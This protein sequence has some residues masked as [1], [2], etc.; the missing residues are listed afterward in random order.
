MPQPMLI[1]GERVPSVTGEYFEVYD[2]ATEELVDRAPMAS[3]DDARRAIAAANAAFRSWRHA[4]AHERAELLHEVA[5]KIR[6][7][8]DELAAL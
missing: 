6:A 4:T 8:T 2:P 5:R 3:E 7:R 1:G